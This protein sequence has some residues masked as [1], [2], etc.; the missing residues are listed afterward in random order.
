MPHEMA[1]CSAA[2][3]IQNLVA[4]RPGREPGMGWVSMFDPDALGALLAL[5]DGARAIALL[6]IGPVPAFIHSPC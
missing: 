6:C 3:A 4:G 5:P 1:L 2:C